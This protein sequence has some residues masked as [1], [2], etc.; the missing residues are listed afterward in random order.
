MNGSLRFR[1]AVFVLAATL[2]I[3][4]CSE[5][6]SYIFAGRLYEPGRGCV[7]T[8]TAIDVLDGTQA[9]VCTR[10]CLLGPPDLDSGMPALYVS[11]MCPPYPRGFDA[12]TTPP[13]CAPALAAYDRNDTCQGDGGSLHPPVDAGTDG[14]PPGRSADAARD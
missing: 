11:T 12:V 14:P 9:G 4:A 1:P 6:T 10:A 5:S 7:D 2:A 13:D 3:A 8:T